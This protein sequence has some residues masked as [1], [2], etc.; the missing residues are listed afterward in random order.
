MKSYKCTN[1][2]ID[3]LEKYVRNCWKHLLL[4]RTEGSVSS[5][6]SVTS[7]KIHICD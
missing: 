1:L 4:A 2:Y 7:V 6:S 3:N 5:V